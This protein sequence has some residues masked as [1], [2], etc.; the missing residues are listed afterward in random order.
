MYDILVI[1]GGVVGAMVLRELSRYDAKICL[2][3]KE[4]DVAMGATRAN[5]G[6]SHAG[7]DAKEGSNK[8]KFNVLGA[9]LETILLGFL[10]AIKNTTFLVWVLIKLDF[11]GRCLHHIF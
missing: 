6:I 10:S 7:F 2:L 9:N 3:E 11:L 4:E 5:S 1:G 8:A